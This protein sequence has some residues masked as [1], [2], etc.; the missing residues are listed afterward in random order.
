MGD[1]G[2][3]AEA[4]GVYF[5]H[6]AYV[7]AMW[8]GGRD[9]SFRDVV[10]RTDDLQLPELLWILLVDPVD[11]SCSFAVHCPVSPFPLRFFIPVILLGYSCAKS[12]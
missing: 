5:I 7:M 12:P 6:M 3:G 4:T 10:R 2:G 1:V 9:G 11:F 8:C